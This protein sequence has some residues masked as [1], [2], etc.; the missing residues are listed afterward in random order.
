MKLSRRQFTRALALGL[1]TSALA[2]LVGAAGP[3]P[4]RDLLVPRAAA[5]GRAG[6][7]L[8]PTLP[9]HPLLQYGAQVEPDKWARVI[10]QK[11]SKGASG[12]AIAASVGA[13]H[14][15]EFAFIKSHVLEVKQK[16]VLR[17]A[18]N[19]NVLYI[20]PDSPVQKHATIDASKLKTA[21]VRAI[22]ADKVWNSSSP[23]TGQG[24]S[25]A[26]VDSG[27]SAH[28]D[29]TNVLAINVNKAALGPNDGHG[30][31]T[32]VMG[33]VKGRDNK[34]TYIGIAPDARG[35]SVK[36][37]DDTGAAHAA[38]LLRGLQWCFDNRAAYNLRV[39]NVSM[40]AGT[41]ESYKTSPVCAAVEQLWLNGV[42]V[43]V[44]AGNRGA[45]ADATWYPP[46]NDPYAITVGA[47]D[48]N[49]TA[50]PGDD[51]L[52]PFSGRGKTQDLLYKPDLVAPG[53]RLV[54]TLASVNSTLGRQFADRVTDVNYLRLSGTS[55]AAPVVA[56]VAALVL[57][58]FPAMAPDQLKWLLLKVANPFATSPD[59]VRVV[60]PVE[61]MTYAK[62]NPW[63]SANQGLVPNGGIDP[64]T[65]AVLWGAQGY[66]DQGYWD[67][68]YWDQGYWDVMS[69]YD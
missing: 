35:V 63:Q 50:G 1:G 39:V 69:N 23:A 40:T 36:I 6:I 49:L 10:V 3:E 13:A 64:A 32:H 55:M 7:P 31:G 67:Q 12:Q 24:V 65:D 54:S 38:D 62:S 47:L 48:D 41:A 29:L 4:G 60:D 21:Y 59:G 18:R 66:W 8:D 57:Q 56:G 51:S 5:A 53:R 34:G 58:R 2:P 15:E 19:P 17:L 26:V 28:P 30:H 22:G 14:L 43:V 27:L 52:A 61:A 45:A 44:A 9:V 33:I 16:T 20:S 46:A 25:V 11:R 42:A 68:G 37:A